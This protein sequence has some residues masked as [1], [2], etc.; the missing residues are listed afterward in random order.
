[1]HG[2]WHICVKKGH[3]FLLTDANIF[4]AYDHPLHE[5]GED[6]L[7]RQELKDLLRK[8]SA[9]SIITNSTP[10]SSL[11]QNVSLIAEG[12]RIEKVM[13]SPQMLMHAETRDETAL[14]IEGTGLLEEPT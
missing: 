5:T 14:V 13:T 4:E 9:E 2:N 6:F 7:Y 3:T 1:M 10:V 12:G 8:H 11:K